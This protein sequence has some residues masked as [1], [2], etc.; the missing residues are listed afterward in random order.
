[1]WHTNL[2]SLDF[3]FLVLIFCSTC[4]ILCVFKICS[5]PQYTHYGRASKALDW[6]YEY[7]ISRPHFRLW[8][9]ASPSASVTL[10]RSFG[11]QRN[12]FKFYF[13]M[14]LENTYVQLSE[15]YFNMFIYD[16][17][18]WSFVWGWNDETHESLHHRVS[19]V[20]ATDTEML[21]YKCFAVIKNIT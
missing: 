9:G 4:I 8:L 5:S 3:F 1:M 17:T 13:W 11:I 16:F 20:V 18:G 6:D 21:I 12:W 10:S 2:R 14:T 15:L 19:H 7:L